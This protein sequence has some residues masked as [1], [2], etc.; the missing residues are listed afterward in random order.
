MQAHQPAVSLFVQRIEPKS[1][2]R[3]ADCGIKL[4]LG[5]VPAH[6]SAERRAQF[7]AQRACLEELP[8]VEV[9]AVL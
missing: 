9:Y 8:I 4:A 3:E 5:T 1:A 7:A 6:Q 2:T